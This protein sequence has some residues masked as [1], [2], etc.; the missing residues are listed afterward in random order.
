M[1]GE[2]GRAGQKAEGSL[3]SD[4]KEKSLRR[5][6]PPSQTTGQV[7]HCKFNLMNQEDDLEIGCQW[8][9]MSPLGWYAD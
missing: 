4:R 8:L 1:R 5:H 9:F 6:L 3:A 2:Q 7:K